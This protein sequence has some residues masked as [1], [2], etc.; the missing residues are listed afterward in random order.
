MVLPQTL[1]LL[2]P[3]NYSCLIFDSDISRHIVIMTSINKLKCIYDICTLFKIY[4]NWGIMSQVD[5]LI[6]IITFCPSLNFFP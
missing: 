5:S 4:L 6:E 2:F 3:I 1:V